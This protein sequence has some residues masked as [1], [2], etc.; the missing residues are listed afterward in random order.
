MLGRRGVFWVIV[1][2]VGDV[3]EGFFEDIR[4]EWRFEVGGVQGRG[5]YFREGIVGIEYL[6]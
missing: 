5:E 6:E 4:F 3:K 1:I 2:Q